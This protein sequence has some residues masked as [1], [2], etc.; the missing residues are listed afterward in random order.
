MR[1]KKEG[2]RQRSKGDRGPRMTK[3]QEQRRSDRNREP[4]ETEE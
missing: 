4:R 3:K 2:K 1:E